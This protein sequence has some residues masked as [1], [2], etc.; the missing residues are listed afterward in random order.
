MSG[1]L[2]LQNDVAE[3]VA[4]A[5]AL[6][7]LPAE[8]A[9]LANARPVNPE[10]YDAYLKGLQHSYKLVPADMDTALQYFELALKKDPNYALAYTGI[11]FVWTCRQQMGLT[12]PKEAA[13]KAKV[14]AQKS[15]ALDDTV[16]EAHYALANIMA[17]GDWDWTGA[18][19]EFKRA[20][21]LNP[22]FPD[23]RIY[24]SHL[25]NITG[26]PDEAMAQVKRVL[27]LDPYNSLFH[28]LAAA[29]FL[30]VRRYDDAIAQAR[31]AQRTNADDPVAHCITEICFFM[32]GMYEEAFA[33]WKAMWNAPSYGN[34]DIAEALD[35]GYAEAGFTG[36][37]RHAA[38]AWAKV[39]YERCEP[40]Y[41]A[42]DYVMAGDKERAL[43]WLEKGFKL[44]DANMAYLGFP[45]FD[46]LRSDPRFQDLV[47][48]MKLPELK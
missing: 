8:Q 31:S 38:E 25:L 30:S 21:E 7:L 24:Y 3:K 39:V 27:E 33:E 12:P 41:I 40:W 22:N 37:M 23:A 1:I 6:K 46:G 5:L 45:V 4:K 9:R 44:H 34:R 48:R 16:A 47:R 20:I 32:K 15:L 29:D 43:E 17:W 36:A 26:R 19:M 2:A 35:R 14:A 11:S 10:A 13:P 42:V 28:S 18:E